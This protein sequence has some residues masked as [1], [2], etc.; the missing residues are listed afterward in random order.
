[1]IVDLETGDHCHI[2]HLSEP[3]QYTISRLQFNRR[4]NLRDFWREIDAS[5]R[6]ILENLH[7]A[8]SLRLTIGFKDPDANELICDFENEL[9]RIRSLRPFPIDSDTH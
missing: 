4:S 7:V 2:S 9:A 1:M 5:E 3:A 6:R 8:Q